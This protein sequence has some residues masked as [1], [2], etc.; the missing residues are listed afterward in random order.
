[1]PKKETKTSNPE[2]APQDE[3]TAAKTPETDT[4]PAGEPATP[5][6]APA[7]GVEV[8]GE[9]A[10]TEPSVRCKFTVERR[11]EYAV[12]GNNV[13]FDVFFKPVGRKHD[14]SMRPI[15]CENDRFWSQT[16]AGEI[17]LGNISAEVANLFQMGKEYYLDFTL[18][19]EAAE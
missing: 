16:P 10:A 1:M 7:A 13:C 18:V 17:R 5:E 3:A 8:A 4:P 6:S 14:A 2:S 15:P 19:A 9:L 12:P 11:V